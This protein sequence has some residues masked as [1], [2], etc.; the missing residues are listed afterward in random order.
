MIMKPLGHQHIT[1]LSSAA[2]LTVPAG[3]QRAL[4]V[5]TGQNVRFRDDGTSPTTTVGIQLATGSPFWYLGD[6]SAV[7]FIEEQASAVLEVSYYE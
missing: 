4:I 7:K 6:L 5:C 2:A 1:S 3:A